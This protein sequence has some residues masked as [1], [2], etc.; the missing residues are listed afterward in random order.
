MGLKGFS[1]T[2]EKLLIADLLDPVLAFM[3]ASLLPNKVLT[4]GLQNV[5]KGVKVESTWTR[6]RAYLR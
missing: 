5:L 4:R 6:V 2:E 1:D 3:V